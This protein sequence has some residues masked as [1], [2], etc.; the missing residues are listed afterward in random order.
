[1]KIKKSLRPIL[2]GAIGLHFCSISVSGQ[3]TYRV[4]EIQNIAENF[5]INTY[6]LYPVVSQAAGLSATVYPNPVDHLLNVKMNGN[7][8]KN[9]NYRLVDASGKSVAVRNGLP[10]H[11]IINMMGMPTGIYI[12]ILEDDGLRKSYKIIKK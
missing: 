5:E 6:A 8:G 10:A 11:F 7:T 9:L 2:T 1:M 12:L 3:Q 4:E